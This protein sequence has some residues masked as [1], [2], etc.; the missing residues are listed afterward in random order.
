MGS[1]TGDEIGGEGWAGGQSFHI[2]HIQ[3]CLA[4]GGA[5][6]NVTDQAAIR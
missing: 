2:L 5:D 3:R 4:I 1:W 6:G